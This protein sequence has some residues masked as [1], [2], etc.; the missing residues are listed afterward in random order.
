ML[1]VSRFGCLDLTCQNGV[2]SFPFFISFEADLLCKI[3]LCFQARTQ[4][5]LCISEMFECAT[6]YFITLQVVI[7]P[8]SGM[9]CSVAGIY[10]GRT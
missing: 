6:I 3:H 2:C 1:Y 9:V 10:P 5:V 7:A 8:I 4:G